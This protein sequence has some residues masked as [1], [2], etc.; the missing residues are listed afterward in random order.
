MER[1]PPEPLESSAVSFLGTGRALSIVRAGP[2]LAGWVVMVDGRAAGWLTAR[3]LTRTT[4]WQPGARADAGLADDTLGA[5]RL[6]GNLQAR[7]LE[8]RLWVRGHVENNRSEEG[9]RASEGAGFNK[10]SVQAGGIKHTKAFEGRWEGES[11][12]RERGWAEGVVGG[13]VQYKGTV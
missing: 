6:R 3:L 10:G 11:R 2:T 7:G 12:G 13:G 5:R 8:A 4:Q 1:L 9:Q